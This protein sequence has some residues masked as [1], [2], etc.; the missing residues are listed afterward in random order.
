MAKRSSIVDRESSPSCRVINDVP[1]MP[2]TQAPCNKYPGGMTNTEPG[3]K[4]YQ[5]RTEGL[6]GMPPQSVP[7]GQ[8]L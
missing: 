4:G 1:N 8:T 2:P 6:E 7:H 3:V 5:V